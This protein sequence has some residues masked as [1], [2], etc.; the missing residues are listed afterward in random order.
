MFYTKGALQF[1]VAAFM[2]SLTKQEKFDGQDELLGVTVPRYHKSMEEENL[3]SWSNPV[4][5]V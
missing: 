2:S 4:Q 1:L 5:D 3:I